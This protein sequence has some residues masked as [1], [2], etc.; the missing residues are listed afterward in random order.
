M[1]V[2]V[3]EDD[4]SLLRIVRDVFEGEGFTTD[5]IE[6]GDDGWYWA[7]KAVHDLIVLDVMLPG[8][9]GIDIVRKLRV[10]N[11]EIPVIILTAK[12]A[13]E[14]LVA[15]LDAGADDYVTKPFAVSELLARTR[16]VLR[17]KG[18]IGQEGELKAG[19]IR[20]VPADR[21][22]FVGDASLN[23]T[24]KEYEM[25]ECFLCNK[26]RIITRDQIFERVWGFD[27]SSELTAVDVYVHHLRKKLASLGADSALRTIRGVG[28]KFTGESDVQ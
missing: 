8:M 5:G 28:Y 14:D 3:V 25:L 19:S 11:K 17:R 20:L 4:A 7:E 22:A 23:L 24:V 16:A 2:L 6:N 13:V 12:D 26:D 21:S 1:R 9:N 10:K 18:T 27:S 15:G